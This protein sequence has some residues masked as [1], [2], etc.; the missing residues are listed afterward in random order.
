MAQ[1]RTPSTPS[2]RYH[3]L[4]YRALITRIRTLIRMK[5]MLLRDAFRAFDSDRNGLLR[6]GL[7][8]CLLS[9]VCC[10]LSAVCCLL[11]AVC[12]LLPTGRY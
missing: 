5:N 4:E 9:A 3:L 2:P 10:L 8:G 7:E 12:C 11:S 6:W 1:H